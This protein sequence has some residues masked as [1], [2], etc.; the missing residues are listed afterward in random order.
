MKGVPPAS[1]SPLSCDQAHARVRALVP[2]AAEPSEPSV[3]II[4]CQLS[5]AAGAPG[6]FE[7]HPKCVR[8]VAGENAAI[9]SS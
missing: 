7:P 5:E 2:L 4:D 9:K 6:K 3:C 1:Q 8:H